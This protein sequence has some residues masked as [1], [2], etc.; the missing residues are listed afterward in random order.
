MPRI[1][2]ALAALALLAAPQPA[3]ALFHI[4]VIDEVMTSYDGDPNVQFVEIEMLFVFQ[5]Q[6][7]KTACSASSTRPA[8]SSTKRSSYPPTSTTTARAIT[9]SWGRR[10]SRRPRASR[11]TSSS[12][13]AC[14]RQSGM[15]CWGAPGTLPPAD[16][17]SWDHTDPANYVDCVAYG[18]YTGPTNVHIGTAT[19]ISPDGHSLQRI[20]ETDDNATDFACGDPANP[21]NNSEQSGS[22]A[23]TI[24]CPEPGQLLL[25]L[26]GGGVLRAAGAA[27][28]SRR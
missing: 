28:R 25:L 10:P 15:V 23:A 3:R 26:V 16:P 1:R 4:A 6:V 22:L 18:S 21:T 24:P 12:R 20:S 17:N 13:P 5:T 14:F 27:R 7:S 8:P 11:W 2:I 9:G 19:P